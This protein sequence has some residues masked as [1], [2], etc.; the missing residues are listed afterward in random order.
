MSNVRNCAGPPV[1]SNILVCYI[2]R[3]VSYRASVRCSTLVLWPESASRFDTRQ[4][5]NL[6][7]V[8]IG[9]INSRTATEYNP[10]AIS[11]RTPPRHLV[12]ERHARLRPGVTHRSARFPGIFGAVSGLRS[13][14]WV[15]PRARGLEEAG[16]I[17]EKGCWRM[18]RPTTELGKR[19]V[20]PVRTGTA[21]REHGLSPKRAKKFAKS[22]SNSWRVCKRPAFRSRSLRSEFFP[23]QLQCPA[24]CRRAACSGK[25]SR[26]MWV[27]PCTLIFRPPRGNFFETFRELF[28]ISAC[29]APK[30]WFIPRCEKFPRRSRAQMNFSI[31]VHFARARKINNKKKKT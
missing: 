6:T 30:S 25:A 14:S 28:I 29:V 3:A 26:P 2:R 15:P 23:F 13:C 12:I 10:S 5:L 11:V 22:N 1:Y 21:I 31:T 19:D 17:R 24:T 9:E 4:R 8:H 27:F 16:D 20:A 7:Y 18:R